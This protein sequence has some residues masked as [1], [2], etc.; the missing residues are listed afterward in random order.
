[1]GLAPK[2]SRLARVRREESGFSLVELLIVVLLLTLVLGATLSV[3]DRT[4]SHAARD[5]ERVAAA[6][7]VRAG[8]GRMIN[9]IRQAGS[10]DN[11]TAWGIDMI[12]RCRTVDPSPNC[13]TV[14]LDRPGTDIRWTALAKRVVWRCDAKHAGPSNVANATAIYR[15]CVR[16]VGRPDVPAAPALPSGLTTAPGSSTC[17]ELAATTECEVAIRRVKNWDN[18]AY[19]T[20]AIFTFGIDETTA[21][22][23][24]V[25]TNSVRITIRVP[26][27]GERR[28]GQQ[29]S[30]PARD[31]VI[32]DSAYLRNIDV[33]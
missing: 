25:D 5:Q 32:K 14:T 22:Q 9:D 4:N 19:P 26:R 6:Q 23:T 16:T 18:T 20:E 29:G 24:V 30:V 10:V 1:M 11:A 3:L 17:S 12:V 7:E 2:P 8:I 21:Q 13:Q 33:G 31:V 27:L 15:E 28:S